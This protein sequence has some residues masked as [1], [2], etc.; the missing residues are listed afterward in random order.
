MVTC[1]KIISILLA[2]LSTISF[3]AVHAKTFN[4]INTDSADLAFREILIEKSIRNERFSC[5]VT[6]DSF[7][8]A[9]KKL[10]A[11]QA[12]M[13][14]AKKDCR[15]LKKNLPET[16]ECKT[17]AH[18][19]LIV[20]VNSGNKLESLTIAEFKKIWNG[21][22]AAWRV[23]DSSNIF[24]IHRYGMRLDD[25]V[26]NFIKQD[27]QLKPTAAHFPLDTTQQII[28]MVRANPNAIGIGIMDKELD[29]KGVKLLRLTDNNGKNINW[30]MPHSAIFRRN[31]RKIA[32]VFLK[33]GKN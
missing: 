32:E 30:E 14:L 16:L 24:S 22:I 2:V 20:F 1:V 6:Q 26:F 4:I 18:T 19:R 10:S 7:D 17:F 25:S 8:N 12:D 5:T 21:E 13:V 11:G 15:Q 3:P 29:L 33:T 9:I 27:L 28:T 31:D 23:F